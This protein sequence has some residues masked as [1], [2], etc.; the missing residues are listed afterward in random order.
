MD[1][2]TVIR[3][4]GRAFGDSSNI[5][6]DEADWLDWI[7]EVQLK[8]V[9]ETECN[10][11]RI[12]PAASAFPYA[13]PAD[14]LRG[15][16]VVYGDRALQL[17]TLSE[18][19]DKFLPQDDAGASWWYYYHD[20]SI[21]LYPDP[22]STDSTVVTIDYIALPTTVATTS[23]PLTVPASFH[24]DIVRFLVMRAHERNENE[25]AMLRAKAEFDEAKGDRV[26]DTDGSSDEFDVVNADEADRWC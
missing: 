2:T 12:T 10:S 6:I 7:N 18:M 3:K 25:N 24:E 16:R 23:D 14:F 5:L 17:T 1:I 4:A 19:D 8:I 21:Y 13:L 9:R 26:Q 20:G 11:T 22:S 15:K